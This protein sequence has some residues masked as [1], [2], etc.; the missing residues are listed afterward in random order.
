MKKWPDV[1]RARAG[2]AARASRGRR[3]LTVKEKDERTD[4][5]L[6]RSNSRSCAREHSFRLNCDETFERAVAPGESH[7]RRRLIIIFF[8]HQA[9]KSSLK[10]KSMPRL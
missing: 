10:S 9:P 4:F 5:D 2:L 1:L 3:A 7:R 6:P 8:A